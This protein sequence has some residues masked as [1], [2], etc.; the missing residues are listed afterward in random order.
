MTYQG[1]GFGWGQTDSA[2]QYIAEMGNG[3]FTVTPYKN[4][5]TFSPATQTVTV[6]G[7]SQANVNFTASP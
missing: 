3:T 7:S 1:I 5:Y 6:S 4:G 2:G